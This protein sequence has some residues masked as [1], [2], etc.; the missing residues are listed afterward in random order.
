MVEA[1]V[2]SHHA[3]LIDNS[4]VEFPFRAFAEFDNGKLV[5]RSND[6]PTWGDLVNYIDV[7]RS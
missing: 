3:L 1:I 7:D 6:V 5:A 4:S 2:R